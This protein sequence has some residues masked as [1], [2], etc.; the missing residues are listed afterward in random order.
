LYQDHGLFEMSAGV[1][2]EKID[3][4]IKSVLKEFERLKTEKVS[5]SDLKKAKEHLL[6]NLFM[7]LEGSDEIG[8][9]YAGQEIMGLKLSTPEELAKRIS[10]V[11]SEDVMAVARQ[12]IKNNRLNLA[13][14]GPFKKRSFLDILRV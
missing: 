11:T 3:L 9:F 13:V 14:I 2:H 7:S 1:E 8:S 5:A 4:V 10:K 6:G 12:I